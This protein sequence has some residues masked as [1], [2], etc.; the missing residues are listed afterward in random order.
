MAVVRSTRD[1]AIRRADGRPKSRS[2]MGVNVCR[3]QPAEPARSDIDTHGTE[4]SPVPLLLF[5][6][7]YVA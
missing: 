3:R 4:A 5:R 2:G 7:G 6:F 1:G